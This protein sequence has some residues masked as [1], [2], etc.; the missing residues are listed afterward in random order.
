M[1]KYFNENSL[2]LNFP[3]SSYLIINGNSEVDVKAD[4]L[5]D[6]CMIE[7]KSSVVYLGAVISDSGNISSDIQ[8]YIDGKRP[9]VT[10]KYNNFIRKNV[11]APLPIKL[12]VLDVCVSSSLMYGCESW[13]IS[14]IP[15]AEVTY[16]LGLKRALSLRDTTNTEIVYIEAGRYPLSTRIAK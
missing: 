1:L 8:E 16:R 10:I 12:K 4:L 5:L 11:M 15:S 14:K 6:F 3:K 2:S 13:G 7:Y 9:N